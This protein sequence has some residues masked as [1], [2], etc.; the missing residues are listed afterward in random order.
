M[1]ALGAIDKTQ[2]RYEIALE[3]LEKEIFVAGSDYE[4]LLK[5]LLLFIQ[6][7]AILNASPTENMKTIL[8]FQSHLEEAAKQIRNKIDELNR[9]A[10]HKEGYQP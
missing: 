7:A 10:S 1:D 6:S 3:S 9:Q 8:T 2:R 5:P 4:S